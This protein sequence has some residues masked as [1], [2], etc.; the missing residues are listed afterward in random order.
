MLPLRQIIGNEFSTFLADCGKRSGFH[1]EKSNIRRYIANYMIKIA[2]LGTFFL[3][4]VIGILQTQAQYFGTSEY[5]AKHWT[6]GARAGSGVVI[7]NVKPLAQNWQGALTLTRHYNRKL[8]IRFDLGFAQH[9]GLNTTPSTNLFS[10][11]VLT[12]NIDSNIVYYDTAKLAAKPF[13]YNYRSQLLYVNVLAKANMNRMFRRIGGEKC[14]IYLLGG[15]QLGYYVTGMNVL[16]AQGKMYDFPTSVGSQKDL[17]KVMDK[18]YETAGARDENKSTALITRYNGL[19]FGGGYRRLLYSGLGIGAEAT[20]TFT[21]TDLL[22]G[23]QWGPTGKDFDRRND[24]L[25]HFSV[26]IDYSLK[27]K[28]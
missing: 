9:S 27:G 17:R 7:G 5:G 8:D 28:K 10:N 16:D 19:T 13:Y 24:H 4:A 23:D 2:H 6:M 22:D 21:N 15:V 18:T 26:F 12:G 20:Y 1:A 14:D 11:D 3:L 25:L